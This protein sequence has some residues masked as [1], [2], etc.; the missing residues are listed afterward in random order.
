MNSIEVLKQELLAQK[1][2]IEEKGGTVSVANLNPSPSEITAAI[3]NMS[4]PDLSNATATVQDVKIGKTYYAGDY[5]LKT[6][7]Y[8]ENA[9][10][11]KVFLYESS[12]ANTTEKVYFTIPEGVTVLRDYA[13][14]KNYNPL[15]IT[16]GEDTNT[17]GPYA[18]SNCDNLEFSNFSTCETL[19]TIDDFC[20]VNTTSISKYL[21]AMPPKLERIGQ[22]AFGDALVDGDSIILPDTVNYMENY[23]FMVSQRKCMKNLKLP[24]NY[25]AALPASGFNYVSFDCDLTFPAGVT[26]IINNFNYRGSFNNVTIHSGIREVQALAFGSM[27]SDP[28]SNYHMKTMTFEGTTVPTF[29]KNPIGAIHITNGLKIYVPDSVVQ[30][31]KNATNFATYA[32]HIY[33][34]SQKP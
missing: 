31:Y 6:G 9:I 4:S 20:F 27:S 3:K 7:E 22:K 17:F 10:L 2:A 14:Y 11:K 12:V 13:F 8:D 18:F 16:I 5:T 32:S 1:T 28:L 25:T 21:D 30:E 24:A 34:M 29:A 23:T 26:S 19:K 33:P 15:V